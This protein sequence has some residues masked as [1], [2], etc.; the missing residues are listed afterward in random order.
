MTLDPLFDFTGKI[1]L[2]AGG[3]AA[4]TSPGRIVLTID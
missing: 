1:V 4:E 2:V 3:T